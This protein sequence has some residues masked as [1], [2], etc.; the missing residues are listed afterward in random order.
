LSRI[1]A[2][3]HLSCGP[4]ALARSIR[5]MATGAKALIDTCS[6]QLDLPRVRRAHALKRRLPGRDIDVPALLQQETRTPRRAEPDG[7]RKASGAENNGSSVSRHARTG[8]GRTIYITTCD[9]Y[10]RRQLSSS[11]D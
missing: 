3:F 2:R 7:C 4:F 6:R 10:T 5:L 8:G 11:R 9:I 1:Q